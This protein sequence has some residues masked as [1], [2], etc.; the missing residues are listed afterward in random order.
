[1]NKL[2]LLY[3]L[4]FGLISI[5]ACKK[6]ATPAPTPTPTPKTPLELLKT[7]TWKIKSFK[8]AN[9]EA[10][11]ACDRDDTMAFGT[12]LTYNYGTNRCDPSE[13]VADFFDYSLSSDGKTLDIVG[14]YTANVTT[15]TA[16]S[17]VIEAPINGVETVFTMSK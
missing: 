10:S 8:V 12:Q 5:I 3:C 6:E 16:S 4:L 1:M 14:L 13:P 9:I 7:G 15:L 11:S 17:L 2:N